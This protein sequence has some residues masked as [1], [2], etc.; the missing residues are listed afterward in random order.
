[1]IAL[2]GALGVA[3]AVVFIA[4]LVRA[5]LACRRLRTTH[6]RLCIQDLPEPLCSLR[7]VFLC[8][9]HAGTLYVTPAELLAAVER[10]APDLLLLGGDYAAGRRHRGAGLDLV[11]QLA[12]GRT[13]FG[14]LGNI[15]HY[16]QFDREQLE[17]ALAPGGGALLVNEARRVQVDGATAE[18]VGLDVPEGA[19][20]D[21]DAAFSQASGDA[22]VRVVLVHSPA[23]W[24]ELAP[25]DAHIVLCGHTHGGQ[26]RPP[27]LEAPMTHLSYPARLAAGLFRYDPR[28]QPMPQRLASHWRI[29]SRGERPITVSAGP[30]PLLYVSRGVGTSALPVRFLCPPEL[31]LIELLRAEKAQDARRADE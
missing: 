11:A 31:V 24:Q 28:Q 23:I 26:I 8:D 30:G 20:A 17:A 29:L 4:I 27:G 12:R 16:V 2:Y 22:D 14:I 5:H 15:E 9:L 13:S 10:A 21:I 25:L 7:L 3:A 19:C 1:M 18:V 6:L